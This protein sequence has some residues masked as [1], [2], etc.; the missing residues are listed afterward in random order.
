MGLSVK[1]D[2]NVHVQSPDHLGNILEA[3]FATDPSVTILCNSLDGPCM[4]NDVGYQG[5]PSP[6]WS[7]DIVAASMPSRPGLDVVD[8]YRDCIRQRN[9]LTLYI[10]FI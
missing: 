5:R 3:W 6:V 7:V 1:L 10:N 2:L 9:S 8:I 4:K